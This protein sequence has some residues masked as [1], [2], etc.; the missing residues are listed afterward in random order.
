[1]SITKEASI[2]IIGLGNIG[3][4][5][6]QNFVKGNRKVILADRTLSKA[7]KIAAE[8]G[9][10]ASPSDILSAIKEADII[11]PAIWFSSIQEFFKEY[12]HELEGKIIIDPSNPIAPDDKGGF[13]KI[14]EETASAGE[15]LL[16]Q[17]PKG[18]KLVK[19]LGTLGAG[20][21]A[22]TAWQTPDPAV[23]FYATTNEEIKPAIEELIVDAGFDPLY[24]GGI[25]Q[26]IRLEVF[27]DLHE[28]GA[29]GKTVTLTEAKG[30]FV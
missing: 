30:E 28:F 6:A 14:I 18:A 10:I 13:V 15:T 22:S 21:L 12:S 9:S 4:T 26:S 20:S 24:V 2:A 23:L 5:L 29:L 19:A 27:G 1:M 3:L 17:L 11:I 8:L 25:D 7:Q 16:S